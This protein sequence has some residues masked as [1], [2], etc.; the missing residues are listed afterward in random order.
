MAVLVER[1]SDRCQAGHLSENRVP[2][3]SRLAEH[4]PITGPR[5]RMQDLHHHPARTR[6][7]HDLL[8]ADPDVTGDERSQLLGQ[9]FRI[10]VGGIDRVD[11]GRAH[12]RQR[13]ERVLVERQCEWVGRVGQRV[14]DLRGD[15]A[16]FH[17]GLHQLRPPQRTAAAPAKS[18]ACAK[19]AIIMTSPVLT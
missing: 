5:Y 3:E 19:A 7:Q 12:R 13:R 10:T 14:E 17:K 4:N 16:R 8:V 11:Q 1:D 15:G 6:S 18:P 9:E 2:V